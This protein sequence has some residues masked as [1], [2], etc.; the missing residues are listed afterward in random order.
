ML[1]FYASVIPRRAAASFFLTDFFFAL[2]FFIGM[3]V[4]PVEVD[5]DDFSLQFLEGVK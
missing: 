3:G 5:G 2:A 4:S 1:Y